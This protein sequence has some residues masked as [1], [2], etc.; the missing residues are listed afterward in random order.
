MF[1]KHPGSFDVL[2]IVI[3]ITALVFTA[4]TL[5]S[6]YHADKKYSMLLAF[7]QFI[8]F[9]I[10]MVG[11]VAG[12]KY[13]TDESHLRLLNRIGLIGNALVFLFT[14]SIMLMAA[15]SK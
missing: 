14:I 15:L 9:A 6:F 3:S 2:I 13:K 8:A 1:R 5:F 10:S 7:F 11:I 12:F 4:A